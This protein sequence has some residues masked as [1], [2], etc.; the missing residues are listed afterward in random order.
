MTLIS[1][2]TP[3]SSSS[4]RTL[5]H[6][7]MIIRY[8][9]LVLLAAL[10]TSVPLSAQTSILTQHYD[11]ARTGQNTTETVLTPSNV[12]STSFGK[13]F[14][15]TVDG[16]VYAQPLYVPAVAIPGNGTH[17]VLYVATEH[18][19]LYAFDADSGSQLWHVTFLIN[20]ATTLTPSNVGG[21]QDINPEIGITGTPTI[22]PTTNTLYVVVNTVESSNIIYRLHAIDITTGAEKLGGPALMTASAPGTAPDGN[23]SSVPFNGQWENQRPGLLL[24]NGFVYIGFA[25]HG[26]NGPW[27]GWILAYNKTTLAQSGVW[28]TSPNG[29]GNGIWQ[30]GAGIAADAAGSAYIATGNGDDTVAT[31]APP[32]S[33]TI[34]YGDSLV[35][36]SLTNGVPVPT[37]YFT[38]WNQA[39]LDSSDTDLAAGG[40]LVLPDQPGS[41][42]HILIQS[43]KQ[44]EVYVVNRDKMT[45][46]GSH[47]CNGCSSD[48]EIIQSISSGAGLWS[49]PAYWNGQIYLWG[50]GG[51]LEAY[52]LTNGMLS[53]SPTSKSAESNGFPGATP[54]VSSNGTTNGVVWAVETDAYTSS[55]PAILRAYNATNVSNLLYGS[56][57]TS[58]R[59]TL[60]PAVKFVVPV[61]TNG[62]VYVGTQQQ[63][64]VFGLLT[65]ESQAIAP[66]FS[67][68]AGSYGA[69]IQVTIATTT[70]S[71][72]IY[73]TIDGSTP[74][75]AST[76]YSGP[77]TVTET[78]TFSAIAI[79]T[80]FVQSTVSTAAYTIQDQTAPPDVSP[81]AGT[82]TSAQ[83]VQLSDTSA[84]PTIYYTTD[85]TKPTHSSKQFTTAISVTSTTTITAIASSPGLNDSPAV[86]ATFTINP[87][88][89]TINF[90]IGFATPTGM[91]FNGS[92]DLDDS[93]LQL[94]N[95]GQTEAGSAF[96]TTPMNITNFTTDFTFQLSDA[97]ADGITF[98]IQN[99]SAGAK[100]LGPTGGGLGYGPD[101]PGGTAGIS[102]SVAVKYDLYNNDGEG[103]DSTGIYTN[104]A[105]PTVP[106][107]DMTSSGVILNNGDTMTVH[108]A[109][110]GTTLAMTITDTT[111][112]ATFST[113]WPINIPQTIGGN[114]A[115]VGFTGGTGGETASQKIETWT[116]AST[117]SAPAQVQTPVITP[118]SESFNGTLSVSI[119]DATGGFSIFYT[120]DGSAP[121]PGA[122]TTKQYTTALSLTATTTL[123][124]IA[125][126][127]GDTN[128]ATATATYTL[129]APTATPVF[130][131]KAGTIPTTQTISITDTTTGAPIYYTTNGSTPTASSTLYA[132]PVTIAATTTFNAI[133]IGT[134]FAPSA[135]ATATYT[136]AP[137]AK[138]TF[139]P[140]AGTYTSAQ[141]VTLSDAS[142]TPTIYY[143][144]NGTTPTH[145]STKF[146]VAISVSST[147]TITAIASS[148]G[149]SDSPAVTATFTINASAPNINFASGFATSTGLQFNGSA[150]LVSSQLQLTNA[151]TQHEAGSVF[152]NTPVNIASFTTNFTFQLTSAVADGFTFTIQNSAAGAT[153][154]GPSGGGLGYGPDSPGGTPGISN[155]VAVKYDLYSN[156]GEGTDSTGLYT[157]GASP[158]TPATD[159]TSSGVVL[160]SGDTMAVQITYNGTTL[161]MT[162]TDSTANK[163]F[164]TSWPVNIPQTIGGNTA[165][166]GFT[167][168]TGG[169]TAIQNIKTWTLTSTGSTPTQVQT[170]VISPGSESFSG[171]ATV[172]ITDATT[173]SSIFYTT[174]G[175]APVPG[176]GTTKQY[177]AALSLT[178]TT[179]LNAIATAPGD[180]NSA[181]ATATYTLQAATPNINFAS[182]FATSTGLQFNGS[183][184]LSN[185]QLELTNGGETE[186]GSVFSTTPI[187]VSSF[188]TNFTFQLTSAV[189]DGFT[190]TIQNSA[191]GVTA[192][193]PTGG[194]LGYGPGAPGGTPGISN[195]VAVKF[196]LYNND[197][198]GTDSTGL[199][200]NGASP[201]TPATDMTSSG[202]VLTSGDTMAVQITYNGT[203]LTMTI[204]NSTA[205]KTFTTSWPINIPQT[206]GGNAAYV[207]FTAGT[208]G[209]TA[210][211]NIKT[212][213]FTSTASTSSAIRVHSGG[214]AYT[215][216]T[217]QTWSADTGFSA[218]Q[219]ASTANSIKN[220]TDP[221][222]Y[223]TERYGSFSYQFAV[224][225]GAHNVTL[226][227][228]EIYWTT[229][230]QRIFNVSINGTQVLT[231]FD[232]VA[233]AGAPLTAIDKTFPVTVSNG[234]VTIQFIL[235]SIDYPKVSAVEIQ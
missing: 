51:N 196:D 55:G 131:P 17:N 54:V 176:A 46:D 52:S 169:S 5:R 80:G 120:T 208:G 128:S 31:P 204:T 83:S 91:Q 70:P 3:R 32:P 188:T 96:F 125:T 24:L 174:D 210:I 74:T 151:T 79:S 67:P 127:S 78:T 65:D 95:G 2:N 184:V 144:T 94:T 182:G 207:G 85:G 205:N 53:Q 63:V 232:I 230:G 165:F 225:N 155:S 77:V 123:N 149:L 158:T 224:P 154:V 1:Y 69:G 133:A 30:S 227:F 147:T 199:Y 228:A 190:F 130:S 214:A 81:A 132:G 139:S 11:T 112:N 108:I 49:M 117:G 206:I 15:L 99:S 66:V 140:V 129:Q 22:D 47:Y 48:P 179:T 36:L 60:G 71:A 168:G 10:L 156:A 157:N 160:T 86:T 97:M 193:G 233:A 19:S 12:N 137:T 4:A 202:V 143:T 138:P 134:G 142:P 34:D 136:I 183:A 113:S 111:V 110:N 121:V 89:T 195:S 192:L 45:S 56:N 23:G 26:D 161:T 13:L 8:A 220:T 187:N 201:T 153:A 178:A 88:A 194:G 222:L 122:G 191:A 219:T 146:T 164:T 103:E 90:G 59:D 177:T 114:T 159:M 163:T 42:P 198:E 166:V 226:K 167:A 75:S 7:L 200:T 76:L 25:A 18:D 150:A 35:R 102:N 84:T 64:N 14:S 44:G 203:T 215:D 118:G 41:F 211:Q 82:Y 180:T 124:A 104:G 145:S 212:W 29:K 68:V 234:T 148:P 38:P 107:T 189:A 105:S 106:A 229:T 109:Y 115:F 170:P 217:G 101:T 235:G 73:Y 62:K 61:V 9:I 162:I 218:G 72:S 172:S 43:G 197:G 186:A 57:L 6:V 39:S 16:Y 87:N 100:A 98:T 33:T 58:G 209:S 92:T 40:V 119:T 141:S 21:T 126:A 223:Q 135:V 171:T 185:S 27:H 116:F 181:T 50:N 221:A 173:G 213:T 28:C 20:G 231:N 152:F 93:R 175:S 37:D 216:S